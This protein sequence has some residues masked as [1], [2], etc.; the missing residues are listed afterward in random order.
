MHADQIIQNKTSQPISVLHLTYPDNH[1]S[2]QISIDGATLKWD[3]TRL[4]YRIYN[5][6]TPLQPGEQRHMRFTVARAP[7]GFENDP[8]VLEVVQNGTFFNNM[9]APQ[10]GYQAGVGDELPIG[11]ADLVRR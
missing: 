3:D 11:I 7:Q 9:I 2:T 4:R 8:S 10:I 6:N 5:F 1:Y